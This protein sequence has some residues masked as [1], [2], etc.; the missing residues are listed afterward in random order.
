MFRNLV[1]NSNPMC[2]VALGMWLR[3]SQFPSFAMQNEHESRPSENN[4]NEMA[5][6]PV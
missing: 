3:F 6:E 1:K 2:D 5:W 4:E